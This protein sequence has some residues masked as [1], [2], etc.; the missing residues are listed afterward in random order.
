MFW[1]RAARVPPKAEFFYLFIEWLLLQLNI[2]DTI[3]VLKKYKKNPSNFFIT[4]W[5]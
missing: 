3:L 1:H 5:F 4:S 2:E